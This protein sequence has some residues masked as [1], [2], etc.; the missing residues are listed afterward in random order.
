ME[1]IGVAHILGFMRAHPADGFA[2][3]DEAADAIAAY[4]PHRERR[5]GSTTLSRYL[6]KA[7]MAGFD[8]V[9]TPRDLGRTSACISI[10]RS[11]AYQKR[12]I[13]KKTKTADYAR[14]RGAKAF[15]DGIT[16][17]LQGRPPIRYLNAGPLNGALAA[18]S[19]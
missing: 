16:S 19:R 9:E 8:R 12:P 14:P 5:D 15:R 6:R 3:P 13:K 2:S 1:A 4:L 10:L 18:S 17:W 11:L 7:T